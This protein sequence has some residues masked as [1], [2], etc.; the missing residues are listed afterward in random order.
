MPAGA[1]HVLV[2]YLLLLTGL[3]LLTYLFLVLSRELRRAQQR[4]EKLS[5]AVEAWLA[6][7]EARLTEAETR[8]TEFQDWAG[9]QHVGPALWQQ[10]AINLNS[11]TQILRMHRR[12]ER[13]EQIAAA[14]SLP[15]N[16]VQLLLKIH[17]ALQ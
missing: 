14:L 7:C 17:H 2:Q 3:G 5:S 15:L 11:R 13:P 12:G 1:I 16:E 6:R 4:Q 10:S 8:I 9:T